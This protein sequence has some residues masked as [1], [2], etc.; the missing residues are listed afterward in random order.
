[1]KRAIKTR[2]AHIPRMSNLWRQWAAWLAGGRAPQWDSSPSAPPK[3]LPPEDSP[4]STTVFAGEPQEWREYLRQPWERRFD[5]FFQMRIRWDARDGCPHFQPDNERSENVCRL[6]NHSLEILRERTCG[7][8]LPRRVYQEMLG[9]G[10][11]LGVLPVLSHEALP[12]P[13]TRETRFSSDLTPIESR[14]ILNTRLLQHCEVAG[15]SGPRLPEDLLGRMW[16][17]LGAVVLQ[18]GQTSYPRDRFIDRIHTTSKWCLLA[19]TALYDGRSDGRL[20][21]NADGHRFESDLL[22][23]AKKFRDQNPVIR[24]LENTSFLLNPRADSSSLQA[25]EVIVRDYLDSRYLRLSV[26]GL[27]PDPAPW[28]A[29]MPFE[30]KTKTGIRTPSPQI[31][32]YGILDDEDLS[33][34]KKVRGG[35]ADIGY[36]IIGQLGIGQFGRVYEAINTGN[37]N[38]PQRVAI[39]VDRIR[40]GRKKQA[41]EAAENI[42]NT[43]RGLSRS[44]HVIRVFDAGKI[45]SERATYHVLQLVDGD[46][47]DNLIGTTG[48]EHASI[49]RPNTQRSSVDEV[50]DEFLSSLTGSSGERWRRNRKAPPFL[51]NP[52]LQQLLDILVSKVLWVEEVH[53]LGYAINDLKNGNVMINRRGQ[54]KGIDLDSYS[55]IFSHI[56]KLPDFFFLAISALQLIGGNLFAAETLNEH[57]LEED[58]L[59]RRLRNTWCHGDLYALSHERLKT[60]DVIT[61][62]EGFIGDSR[63]GRFA[64]DPDRFTNAIDSLIRLKRSLAD[65]EI[66]LE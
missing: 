25:A 64:E 36:H 31:G 21:P 15:G 54:F 7:E 28:L 55:P 63:S 53:S 8:E 16:P 42:M 30:L 1:M 52:S 24:L 51:Q 27:M 35:L 49:L 62:F 66:V 48:Y 34:W 10:E 41:I 3:R 23:D 4:V 12:G 43:A 11:A 44:P 18:L 32:H 2:L 45:K 19:L 17:V 46:T 47:L 58:S 9:A 39:K 61:F 20:K 22:E 37:G 65:D 40:K 14:L 59:G 26:A 57:G 5:K 33:A 60:E 56:D 29:P 6:L 38:L 50:R 13:A